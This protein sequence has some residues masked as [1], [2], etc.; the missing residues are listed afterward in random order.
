MMVMAVNKLNATEL[1]TE[2]WLKWQ[3]FTLAL[4]GGSSYTWLW[5]FEQGA[6]HLCPFT[7]LQS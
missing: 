7:H 1:Y 4:F 6:M 2:K 5:V 3:N